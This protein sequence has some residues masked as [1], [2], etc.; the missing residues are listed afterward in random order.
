M[1][2]TP[3]AKEAYVLMMNELAEDIEKIKPDARLSG[4]M[5]E[6]LRQLPAN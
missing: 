5:S 2:L 4:D 3:A 1:F 6:K